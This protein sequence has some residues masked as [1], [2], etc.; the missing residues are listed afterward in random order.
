M[1]KMCQ[2]FPTNASKT[3]ASLPSSILGCLQTAPNIG[4]PFPCS[5]VLP[6]EHFFPFSFTANVLVKLAF[7]KASAVV[8]REVLKPGMSVF[9]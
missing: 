7:I 6:V 5:I 1:Q 4:A 9:M 8:F 3:L 2:R